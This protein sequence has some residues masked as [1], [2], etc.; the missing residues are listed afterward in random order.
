MCKTEIIFLGHKI[1]NGK[2]FADPRRIEK[3]INAKFPTN[4]NL[5]RSFLGL[6]NS[7]RSYLPPVITRQVEIL[8]E[9]TKTKKGFNPQQRH[10]DAFDALKKMLTIEPLFTSIIDPAGHFYLFCDAASGAKASFSAVL[11]QVIKVYAYNF[12]RNV[13]IF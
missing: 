13:L 3:L 12:P 4:L 9:L 1:S 11:T 10:R 8:Q 5:I 2:A 7:L 6:I